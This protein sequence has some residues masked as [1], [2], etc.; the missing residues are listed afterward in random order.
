VSA[1]AGRT[2]YASGYTEYRIYN[3]LQAGDH[4]SAVKAARAYFK[5]YGYK[6]YKSVSDMLAAVK[7]SDKDTKKAYE[8]GQI[9][10][11]K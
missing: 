3:Y 2:R 5:K 1:S 11:Q 7:H 8:K 10:K 6:H 9:K 4:T